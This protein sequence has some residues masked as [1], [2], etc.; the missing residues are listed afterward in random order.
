LNPIAEDREIVDYDPI[1]TGKNSYWLGV[2][3][4]ERSDIRTPEEKMQTFLKVA[5][6]RAFSVK[7]MAA[8]IQGEINEVQGIWSGLVEAKDDTKKI[9]REAFDALV[10]G[11]AARFLAQPDAINKP[12]FKTVSAVFDTLG[13]D[14]EA[15][16]HALLALGAELIEIGK[17]PRDEQSKIVGETLFTLVNPAGKTEGGVAAAK[18]LDQ[19]ATKVDKNTW[20]VID[21][22][23]RKVESAASPE[24]LQLRKQMLSDLLSKS[25]LLG[26]EQE[27]AGVPRGFLK[28]CKPLEPTTAKAKEF[29]DEMAYY[30][31][32]SKQQIWGPKAA[33]IAGVS[34]ERLK[35][36][37]A[38]E[39]K[40]FGLEKVSK[41]YRELFFDHFPELKPYAADLE[42]HHRIE[43]SVL[44]RCRRGLFTAKEIHSI[45][46]LVAI[47]RDA[48]ML[49]FAKPFK[50]ELVPVHSK[51]TY[52]WEDFFEKY[53]R[54]SITRKDVLDR[55]KLIDKLYG[56]YYFELD[57]G[58]EVPLPKALRSR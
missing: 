45:D 14:R 22:A 34:R 28:D 47:P 26:P 38:D 8:F 37:S 13:K 7:G 46:N 6:E 23:V 35:E 9:A 25:G 4:S 49:S 41:G 5:S 55:V 31:G 58:A 33:E 36:M 21:S 50:G 51:I 20:A 42:V 30:Q 1:R 12:L 56:H 44:D 16:N 10:D 27:F 17:L 52:L 54:D 2:R 39:L 3:M 11:R 18:L 19:I 43:Q 57:K 24:V 53:P 29:V 15:V 40:A 48:K 32:G